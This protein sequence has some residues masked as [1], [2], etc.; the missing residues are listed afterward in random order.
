M[1]IIFGFRTS[2][3]CYGNIKNFISN[4]LIPIFKGWYNVNEKVKLL[5]F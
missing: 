1:E 3:G 5:G 4:E 2:F